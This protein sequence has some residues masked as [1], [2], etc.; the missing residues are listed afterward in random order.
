MRQALMRWLQTK[1]FIATAV[2]VAVAAVGTITGFL[3]AGNSV[4]LHK[5]AP[6][7][8]VAQAKAHAHG[9]LLS[10]FTGER[11]KSLGRVLIV[12]I[13]NIVLARPQ[14]GLTSADIIYV[15]PVEGGLTR[16]MAVFSSHFPP[17]IG[18]VRSTRED[19]IVLLRQFNRP[20]FAFSGA[21]PWLLPVVEHSRIIDLYAGRVAGYHRDYSRIAPYNLFAD[22]RVLLA[23]SKRASKAHD[24]GFR[25]GSAPAGG[26][27]TT[28]MTVTYPA[29]SY[30]FRWSAAKKRWLVWMDGQ[31]ALM[32]SGRQLAPATVVIQYVEVRTSGF[33]EWGNLRPPYAVTTGRG[34]AIVLRNG[35]AYNVRWSRRYAAGGTRFTISGR[36]MTFAPGQVWV[37]YVGWNRFSRANESN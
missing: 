36:R 10:P 12:K 1:A 35:R 13:D 4:V 34:R 17:V 15:L 27:R 28:S 22:T 32:T 31:P 2:A 16:F 3:L 18:P 14:T 37:V 5:P 26:R 23:E 7:P 9:P 8:T 19:D 30:T 25:F 24:I 11:V 6:Q 29:A 21:Q 33:L 20:A